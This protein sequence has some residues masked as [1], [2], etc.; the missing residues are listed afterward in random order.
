M[1]DATFGTVT[2]LAAVGL[3]ALT[4]AVVVVLTL[5]A[6]RRTPPD[7]AADPGIQGS[8]AA[9]RAHRHTVW[10]TAWA[11]AWTG[12]IGALVAAQLGATS[13]GNDHV[14]NWP[15]VAGRLVGLVPLLAGAGFLLVHVIGEV[16]W[17]RPTGPVRRAALVPRTVRDVT[18]WGLPAWCSG[19]AVLLV[20]V[21]VVGGATADSSGRT[22]T[23]TGHEWQEVWGNPYPGWYYGFLLLVAVAVLAALTVLV[24]RM[25]VRRATV[26]EIHRS[27]DLAL[28]RVSA[29]RVLV[30]VQLVTGT[31]L[32][33]VLA[34][35]GRT[36][37]HVG[38]AAA[39]PAAGLMVGSG[40]A[41]TAA[42]WAVLAASLGVVAATT[43]R[44]RS[45]RTAKVPA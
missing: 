45:A 18:G 28:R 15:F 37:V 32:A 38:T 6:G 10:V 40:R 9:T 23:R 21:T 7:A 17:P 39:D 29:R 16:T 4:V 11:W 19:L 27:D 22:L 25:L 8:P 2:M 13:A 42:A 43:V 20:V 36:L 44:G 33:G 35:G 41:A 14:V 34:V 31:T 24:L 1:S 30:G 3:T 26:P 12:G 5:R